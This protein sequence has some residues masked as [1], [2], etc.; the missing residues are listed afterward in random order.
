[1]VVVDEKRFLSF[2]KC[3]LDVGVSMREFARADEELQTAARNAQGE[4]Q[5]AVLPIGGG[6]HA[7]G[8]EPTSYERASS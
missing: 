4:K 3:M 5:R 6:M 2:W 7:R 1:M 8:V